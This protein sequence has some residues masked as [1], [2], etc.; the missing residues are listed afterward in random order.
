MAQAHPLTVQWLL[1]VPHI[2]LL[3]FWY[4][5]AS[6]NVPEMRPSSPTLLWTFT[7]CAF[8]L[9]ATLCYSLALKTERPSTVIAVT[10]AY[11]VISFLVFIVLGLEVFS[12]T[13]TLGCLLV[14]AGVVLLQSQS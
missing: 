14:V 8:T 4:F 10:S 9:V 2:V 6:K 5:V 3:P 13:Q 11:P 1:S 7:S 12:W